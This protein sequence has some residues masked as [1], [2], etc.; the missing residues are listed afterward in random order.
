MKSC[1]RVSAPRSS[2]MHILASLY[3]H[4]KQGE[5]QSLCNT[6]CLLSLPEG[7]ILLCE[8]DTNSSLYL[9][10]SGGASVVKTSEC[11]SKE[12]IVAELHPGDPIGEVALF[13]QGKRTASVRIREQAELLHLSP[14]QLQAHSAEHTGLLYFLTERLAERL[15]VSTDKV[16][17]LLFEDVTERLLKLLRQ[18]AKPETNKQ[19][20][21]LIRDMPSQKK[22]AL[23]LGVS[24]ETV[25]RALC[26]LEECKLIERVDR[27]TCWVSIA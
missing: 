23:L 7:E 12:V 24:R 16:A 13:T 9:L 1:T 18:L 26:A 10:L 14:S 15:Q 8:G 6:G 20:D 25:S 2:I 3:P 27:E 5:I 17:E 21:Q 4:F 11:K 22:L 19:A